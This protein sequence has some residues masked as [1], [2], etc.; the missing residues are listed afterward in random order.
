MENEDEKQ[1][2]KFHTRFMNGKSFC[3]PACEKSNALGDLLS[4]PR[5]PG[6]VILPGELPLIGR[7]GFKIVFTGDKRELARQL[8]IEGVVKK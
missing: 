6:R 4:M 3:I 7:M 5:T 2:I 1:V 8:K